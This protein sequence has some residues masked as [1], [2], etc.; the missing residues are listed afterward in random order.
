VV[1]PVPALL[2]ALGLKV[3]ALRA[4]LP[5]AHGWRVFA[6]RASVPVLR[7]VQT[8]RSTRAEQMVQALRANASMACFRVLLLTALELL[9]AAASWPNVLSFVVPVWS[10]NVLS[11]AAPA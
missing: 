8:E 7:E 3:W 5:K 9:V 1:R 6:A 2:A 11:T 4:L 10:R